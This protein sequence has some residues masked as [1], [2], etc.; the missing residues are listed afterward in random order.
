M[1]MCMY[2]S[3]SSL[4]LLCAVFTQLKSC[5]G[6]EPSMEPSH[7]FKIIL[8]DTFARAV[9]DNLE[10]ETEQRLQLY[11][12]AA[13]IAARPCARYVASRSTIQT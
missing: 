10:G 4:V 8:Y 1:Y 2:W 11:G 3:L 5:N 6:Q 12:P 9:C 13:P 7:V